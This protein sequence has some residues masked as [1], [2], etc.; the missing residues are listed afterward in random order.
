MLGLFG[1]AG[2]DQAGI[3]YEQGAGA[4]QCA[5]LIEKLAALVPPRR[6]NLVR[7]HGVLAPNAA[8]RARIV[9]GPHERTEEREADAAAD[10]ELTPAQ[11]RHRVAWADLLRRVFRVDVTEC[12]ACGGH[13]KVIAALTEPRS[14]QRYLEAVGLPA[15]A[16]P[17]APA[18]PHPQHEFDPLLTAS[19]AA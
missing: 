9:P 17:I 10:G 12:P 1:E 4:G 5:E 6:L 11:R 13:M 15:R 8:D 7:Y 14:I 18:R 19:D 16:P 2:L 3:G